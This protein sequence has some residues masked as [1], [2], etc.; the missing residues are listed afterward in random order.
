MAIYGQILEIAVLPVT[1]DC[2]LRANPRNRRFAR[3]RGLAIYG[4]ISKNGILPVSRS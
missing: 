2:H 1:E 3:N 4:Q